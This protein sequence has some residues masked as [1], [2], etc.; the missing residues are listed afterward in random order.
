MASVRGIAI[1]L[2]VNLA[3]EHKR[4]DAEIAKAAISAMR[5]HSMVPDERVKVEV[6][7]GWVTLTGE[8][9]D[10]FPYLFRTSVRCR[11]VESATFR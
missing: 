4:S 1:D 7:S 6:E 5:W 2:E 3:P 11:T 10:S 9:R 8:R